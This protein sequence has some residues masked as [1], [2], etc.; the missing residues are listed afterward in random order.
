MKNIFKLYPENEPNYGGINYLTI[1][2]NKDYN[3]Y[4]FKF[5]YYTKQ[6]TWETGIGEAVIAFSDIDPKLIIND[7]K[8]T[9]K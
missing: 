9:I 3:D 6:D 1:V 4:Y 8:K 7:L 5:T 2:Y